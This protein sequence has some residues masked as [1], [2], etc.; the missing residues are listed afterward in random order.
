M[1]HIPE[2]IKKEIL[3]KATLH[4]VLTD[5]HT[6]HKKSGS[7]YKIDCP[8]CGKPGKLEYNEA[9][10]VAKCFSCDIGVK[11]PVNY[12]T[13]YHNLTYVQALQ[14]L[15]RIEHITIPT[16]A[17]HLQKQK[18]NQVPYV[19]TFLAGSGLTTEDIT[20]NVYVDEAS[21]KA[22]KTYQSATVDSKFEIVPG[23]DVIIH[24]HDLNGKPMLYYKKDRKGNAV[25]KPQPFYR[26]RY[27]N[28]DLHT[29]KNGDPVKY[30][31]PW[32]SDTKIYI[33]KW[34]RTKYKKNSKIKTLYVQE[35]EKK[36]D[37]ATKHGLISVGVMGIH[38]IAYNKR[39]PVEFEAIIKRCQV[40]NVVFV[41]DSDWNNLSRKIDANHAADQRPKSFYRAVVNFR[42]HFYA[43][44][45]SDIHLNIYFGYVKDNIEQDKGIDDL[46]VNTLRNKE[47]ELLP[48]CTEALLKPDG[49]AKYLQ[50][51]KITS[52]SE[53]KL[54][55]FWGLQNKDAF[56]EKYRDRLKDVPKFRIGKIEW[57]F[58][59]G[60]TVELAQ[61]LLPDEQFWEEH[62][63]KDDDG[64]K[65]SSK[66]SFNYKRCYIFLRNRGFYRL[67]QPGN[68]FIW[69]AIQDNIVRQVE[70]FQICDFVINFTEQ[71]NKEPVENMLY[72]GKQM[73][74]GPNSLSSLPFTELTLHQPSRNIQYLYFKDNYFK[75]T[76]EGIEL[77]ETKELN[78]QVWKDNIKDFVPQQTQLLIQN[79]Q[80]VTAADAKENPELQNYIG[81]YALEFSE[82]GEACQFLT[83]LLN[84]STYF[85]KDKT[86]DQATLA[87]RFETTRHLMSKITAFGY[88]LHR[89]R[90][91]DQQKAVIAMDG[92][93]SEVGQSNG[94]S[95]KSLLG[96]AVEKMLPTVTIPGKRRDLLD[97]KYVF[98][99][100]DQRTGCV[101]FDDVRANF[102]FEFLFPYI[103]GKFTVEKKGLGKF[104]LPPE[105]VIKFYITT[106]HAING[107]SGSFEDRQ[108]YI[109]FSNWYN[110]D[111]KPTDDFGGHFFDDW[112]DK[113]WNLFYNLA[114][115]SIHFY[116]KYGLIDAPDEMLQLR[117]LRQQMG[118]AFLDWAD[119]YFCNLN[120]VQTRVTKDNMYQARIGD[121]DHI[122]H[123][124]GFVT[125]YPQ[126]R[127]FTTIQKFKA[128]I[129]MYC[130]YKGYD[131]NPSK[132]G[133][134]IK[135][136]GKE[137][138]EVFLP[139]EQYQRLMADQ[140]EEPGTDNNLV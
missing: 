64:N 113:Q 1:K 19:Q 114:A 76:D 137:Y 131:Y 70:P 128:K 91:S 17:K 77:K 72:K 21:V 96:L 42:D 69:V 126:Q 129:K 117:K 13:K 43:F 44:T 38:N 4:N 50:F 122:Q 61:P 52:M 23:D 63:K 47:D 28:P 55:D 6:L 120:N 33:P 29:D 46:L 60:G 93:M 56:I 73:Y 20:D 109:A 95:G 14:E 24:Y 94:R 79:V 57:R 89:Y 97:D 32:G 136:G 40:E 9:K 67:S 135:S 78:G 54:K 59:D 25:G 115:M 124:D 31:S 41:L 132:Q 108:H 130:E 12:L 121:G 105:Y 123:G 62:I 112:D 100:V 45:N 139:E 98:E 35:G 37:K 30:R 87:E 75:I 125:K 10:K 18:E 8:K 138:F 26:V 111:Y 49:D 92:T 133:G 102:D 11:S 84:T 86:F 36:A 68:S 5:Y 134:D 81:E 71:L 90:T 110:K 74:F 16:T 65:I 39:L 15:A 83:F 82:E 53:H 116:F 103:T 27:Q 127:R 7:N 118:E 66:I 107:D 106:N 2:D 58:T 104:T 140:V 22:K 85:G 119:E 101:F 3:D 88:L 80:Q 34:V 99:E 51:H 48:L